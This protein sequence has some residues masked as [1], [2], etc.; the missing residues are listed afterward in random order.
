[1]N[2]K[3]EI[4]LENVPVILLNQC[5]YTPHYCEENVWKLADKIRLKTINIY[6]IVP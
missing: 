4:N 6:N 1:M 3:T 2:E 5:E